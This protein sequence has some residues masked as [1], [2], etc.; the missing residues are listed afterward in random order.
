MNFNSEKYGM[1]LCSE[2]KGVGYV[3]NPERQCC[4]QC[5]GFGFI[6]KGMEEK[7]RKYEATKIIVAPS[8]VSR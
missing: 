5:R 4:P 6:I 3:R 8:G 7:I 2:C 1:I